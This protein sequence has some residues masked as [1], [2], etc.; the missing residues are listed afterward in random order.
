MHG[1]VRTPQ[2]RPAV[3]TRH[4]RMRRASSLDDERVAAPHHGPDVLEGQDKASADKTEDESNGED[5]FDDIPSVSRATQLLSLA[6]PEDD[7][8]AYGAR[9][10]A[11]HGRRPFA[12]GAHPTRANAV[13]GSPPAVERIDHRAPTDEA[14]QIRGVVVAI[15]ERAS[16]LRV[17]GQFAP[18]R[19]HRVAAGGTLGRPWCLL[20]R[21]RGAVR[22]GGGGDARNGSC[23]TA[24]RQAQASQQRPQTVSFLP[25]NPRMP[26]F[27]VSTSDLPA[28]VL[29]TVQAG[30][31][32]AS[33]LYL[34]TFVDWPDSSAF[35]LGH[36]ESELGLAG[37][38]GRSRRCTG[39]LKQAGRC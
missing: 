28:D 35:P 17:A 38:V 36:V 13:S 34:L 24:R 12:W 2:H 32:G 29:A 5:G 9:L 8:A 23:G 30:G 4:P 39:A 14:P 16:P 7:E 22:S 19:R 1:K 15:L 37:E 18:V 6:E 21:P 33:K 26:P 20:P 27:R 10:A 3:P 31:P 11:S 25:R